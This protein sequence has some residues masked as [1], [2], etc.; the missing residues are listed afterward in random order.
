MASIPLSESALIA[1]KKVLR[2]HFPAVRS[3]HMT[4]AMA[5]ALGFRTHAA[6][7]AALQ[8]QGSDLIIGFMDGARFNIRLR[9]LGYQADEEFSFESVIDHPNLASISEVVTPPQMAAT[10]SGSKTHMVTISGFLRDSRSGKISVLGHEYLDTKYP[11]RR[12]AKC[13]RIPRGWCVTSNSE[14]MARERM[15]TAVRAI[16]FMD[17]TGL[18]P[19]DAHTR[20]YGHG[21]GPTGFDHSCVWIDDL[22]RYIVTTEPYTRPHELDKAIAWCDANAWPHLILPRQIGI[23]NPCHQGCAPACTE[24]SCMLLT[25]PPK[26]GGDLLAVRDALLQ[27]EPFPKQLSF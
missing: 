15:V 27:S 9:E 21:K 22:R 12:Y 25:A 13:N 14:S 7:Q 26:N 3:A 4:E 16:A 20:L 24:H 8:A 2:E 1:L 5:V 19:S 6:L 10:E 18:R 17:A 23:W 11:G